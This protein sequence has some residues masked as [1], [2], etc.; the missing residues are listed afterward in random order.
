[1]S[2]K[3]CTVSFGHRAV[4]L[5]SQIN[6]KWLAVCTWLWKNRT[7]GL[8]LAGQEAQ[9]EKCEIVAEL[10]TMRREASVIGSG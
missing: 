5:G 9:Q 7:G 10:E 2:P 4:T 1:M 6:V 3:E 8:T